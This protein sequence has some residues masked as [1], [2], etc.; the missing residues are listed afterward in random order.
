SRSRCIRSALE[1]L[2]PCPSPVA[3]KAASELYSKLKLH[4]RAV[5]FLDDSFA[6]SA[7]DEG[8]ETLGF[9]VGRIQMVDVD[10]E[11]EKLRIPILTRFLRRQTT[12]RECPVCTETYFDVDVESED[13]WSEACAGFQ[14][15]WLWSLP[16]FPTRRTMPDC[17]H[18]LDTCKQ[19]IARSLAA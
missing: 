9:D 17:R 10:Y 4:G 18:D 3:L 19:C 15:D 6:A 16:M 13:A 7:S 1:R 14:G 11:G 5:S 12:P 8:G 2:D